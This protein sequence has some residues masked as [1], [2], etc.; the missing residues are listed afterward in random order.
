MITKIIQ[1]VAKSHPDIIPHLTGKARWIASAAIPQTYKSYDFFLN[2]IERMVKNVYNGLIAGDF[3]DI[4]ANLIS[5]QLTDAYQQAWLDNSGQLPMP[6]YLYQ[7]AENDI[8][9]Q[10]DYVDAFYRAII[11]ARIDGTSLEPLL[12]RARLWAN[13]WDASYNNGVLIIRAE[14][15]GNLIWQVGE[16]EH[17]DTCLK[18][19]GTVASAKDWT[20]SGWQPQSRDL[21]CHG[22]N[23]QCTLTPT[24]QRRSPNF[25]SKLGI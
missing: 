20:L 5:G 17:C 10:Y 22:Y 2:A 6:Q 18:L 19:N 15:G 25:R 3:I 9:K 13:Q 24:T 23:C 12:Y 11:D 7:A 8:L 14:T 4:M 16:T 1:Y 21:D